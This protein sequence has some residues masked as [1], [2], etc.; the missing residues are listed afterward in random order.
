[1]RVLPSS[2]LPL[3]HIRDAMAKMF[4]AC[5]L[6]FV[7]TCLLAWRHPKTVADASSENV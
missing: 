2:L 4:T 3:T 5:L 1:M 6:P 7:A